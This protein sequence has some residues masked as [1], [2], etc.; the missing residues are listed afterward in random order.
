MFYTTFFLNVAAIAG[1][2]S[3]IVKLGVDLMDLVLK[4]NEIRQLSKQEEGQKYKQTI[5]PSVRFL[6]STIRQPHLAYFSVFVRLSPAYRFQSY[7][8]HPAE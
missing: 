3:T 7:L 2:V 4:W 1:A 8:A 6:Q 5:I